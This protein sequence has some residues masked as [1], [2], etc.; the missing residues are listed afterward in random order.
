MGGLSY[1]ITKSNQVP[2]YLSLANQ[3]LK[4]AYIYICIYVYMSWMLDPNSLIIRY[5]DPPGYLKP[6]ISLQAESRGSLSR[7]FVQYPLWISSKFWGSTLQKPPDLGVYRRSY[8]PKSIKNSGTFLASPDP[9]KDANG[10]STLRLCNL[11][12]VLEFRN[13]GSYFWFLVQKP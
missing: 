6:P 1:S 7:N 13:L 8:S 3:G 2:C 10:G 12:G 11:Q 4:T 9:W 5:L